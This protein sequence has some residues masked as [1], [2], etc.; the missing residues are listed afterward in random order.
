[1]VIELYV[2]G[3]NEVGRNTRASEALVKLQQT[4]I[5][6]NLRPNER[7]V[8]SQLAKKLGMSRTPL[9]EA[10]KHL[11]L[12]GYVTKLP[13]GGYIVTEHSPK[14]IRDMYEIREALENMA[15]Q[16]ACNRITEEQL[17]KTQKYYNLANDAADRRDVEQFSKLNGLFHDALL[18]GCGNNKM[19]SLIGTIRDQYF[20][21]R[22]LRTLGA[23]EWRRMTKQHGAMLEAVRQG[24]IK[25]A[26]KAASEHIR[27]MSRLAIERL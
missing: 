21:R 14:E 23:R 17:A 18:D 8:E 19:V 15:I 7:L 13:T 25:R 27:M 24:N 22:L 11:H 5:G 10:L 3:N 1:M 9:R 12:M 26:Q 6:G 20:D 16:L 2:S 4:I